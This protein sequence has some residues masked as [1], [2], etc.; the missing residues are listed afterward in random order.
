MKNILGKIHLVMKAVPYIK[1]DSENS[2]HKYSY[3]SELAIKTALGEAFREHGIVFQLE[4]LGQEIVDMGKD[5]NNT[6]ILMTVVKCKYTFH[7]IE[8]AECLSGEFTSSGPA[9]DDKGL[10]AATTNAI[11]YILTSTFLI[12][13]GDD[14][15]NDSNHPT[16]D[17]KK[18][19]QTTK[20]TKTNPKIPRDAFAAKLKS[21]CAKHGFKAI[22]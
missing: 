12:P 7:D 6:P 9:R 5:K 15:E 19:T 11:K 20:T 22:H 17:K 8:S 3:A 1:K 2:F 14:A 13:T 10:W 18:P 16:A 21:V 4:T